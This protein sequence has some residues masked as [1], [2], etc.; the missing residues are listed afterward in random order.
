VARLRLLQALEAVVSTG[1][2][3]R[4]AAAVGVTQPAMSRMITELESDVGCKLFNRQRGRFEL[5]AQG[6]RFY[7]EA[8]TAA[9]AAIREVDHLAQE[10]RSDDKRR[11][12][13]IVMPGLPPGIVAGAVASFA[14]MHP[15]VKVTVQSSYRTGMEAA[16]AAGQFDFALAT[17]PISVPA[18]RITPLATLPAVCLV[19]RD[20]RFAVHP[21]IRPEHLRDVSFVS[22][23]RDA[24][25][26]RH[27]DQLFERMGIK[28]R[29]D[30]EVQD[31][32]V[33]LEMVAAGNGVAITH[34]LFHR[35]FPDNVA[36]R[37]FEPAIPIEYAMLRSRSLL[38]EG[39]MQA[40]GRLLESHARDAI[41]G[42][43]RQ[44]RVRQSDRVSERSLGDGGDVYVGRGVA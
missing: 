10:L 3:T 15:G 39:W 29:L 32:E 13:V 42:A 40:F 30:Y 9:L 41:L 1:S 17:L 43:G 28:R 36:M 2:I 4:A 27:V 22:Q 14:P 16:I 24:L 19:P 12:R 31:R 26:R 21:I 34:P 35:P 23:A 18:A 37:A 25:V 11:I 20:R 5:T 6:H 8:V 33:L 38:R 7:E 44:D